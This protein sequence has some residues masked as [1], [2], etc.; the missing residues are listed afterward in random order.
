MRKP[1]K[2]L[3][4]EKQ[5]SR[6]VSYRING[7]RSLED[8]ISELNAAHSIDIDPL[9]INIR[10]DWT[11]WADL[12]VFIEIPAI[13]VNNFYYR[14]EMGLYKKAMKDYNIAEIAYNSYSRK[15]AENSR[16]RR[17]ES[18]KAVLR[19]AKINNY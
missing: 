10:V 3:Q 11:D 4:P 15:R 1:T 5:Y 9:T 6:C 7:D 13:K 12:N 8:I 14:S 16:L 17:I 2:P 19:A 18:A